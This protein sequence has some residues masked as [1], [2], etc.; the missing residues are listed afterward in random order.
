M[1]SPL[2]TV[3]CLCYNHE[4]FV[5]EALESVFNQTH[6]T[7]QLIVID[8]ASADGSV[9]VIRNILKEHPEVPF[10]ALEKNNGNCRAFNQ[11]IPLI[12]GDFVIDF[13]ADDILLPSRIEEGVKTFNHFGKEYGIHFSDAENISEDSQHLSF[14]SDRFPHSTIPQGDVYSAVIE[15]Y[16]ICGPSVMIRTEVLKQMNGYDETLAYEDF[17]LWIRA[18]REFKFCYTPKVLIRRREVATSLGQQQFKKGSAQLIS[19]YKVCLK[20]QKLNRTRDEQRALSKRVTYE[21]TVAL[22]LSN[23]ALAIRYFFLWC[24]NQFPVLPDKK[25]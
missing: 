8:D 17:D 6:Q 12:K 1:Q 20:I 23:F 9:G 19:T 3:V 22:R 16:F 21:I 5:K 2:V 13:S 25:I 18:A 14:H 24:S 10:L 15:K 7:V 4:R 11:A